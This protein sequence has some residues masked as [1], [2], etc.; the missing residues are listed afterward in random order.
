MTAE[1]DRLTAVVTKNK[2]VS[3]SVVLLIEGLAQQLKDAIA[4]GANPA[5]LT[6]LA[7]EIEASANREAEAVLANTPGEP[8][9]VP[10]VE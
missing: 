4:N 2:E 8:V 9:V 1:M 3:D 5:E 6:R 10:P 7:D